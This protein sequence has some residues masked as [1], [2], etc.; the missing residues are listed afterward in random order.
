[1]K[2]DKNKEKIVREINLK[3]IK[4][5]SKSRSIGGVKLVRF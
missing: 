3:V 5:G 4:S 2:K 1:M